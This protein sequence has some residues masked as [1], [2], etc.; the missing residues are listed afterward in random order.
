MRRKRRKNNQTKLIMIT[1]LSLLFILTVGYAAFSTN[2]N[3]TAKGNIKEKSRV[4]KSYTKTSKEDFH[5]DYYRPKIVTANFRKT[6]RVPNNAIE[7]W[8]VS[9]AKDGGVMA[10]LV[11]STKEG[12]YD[13]FIGANNGVIAN[14]NSD[15]L[16]FDFQSLWGIRFDSSFDT[17]NATSMRYMFN[18]GNNVE[19]IDLS[20]F[21]TTN[22]TSMYAMFSAWNDNLNGYGNRATTQIIFGENF[23]TSKVTDM[24]D[25]FSG[26]PLKSLNLSN[27]NTSNVTNMF[28]M[29]NKCTELTELNLCSFNTKNAT[30]MKEM[31]QYTEKIT[32]VKVGPNWV[33]PSSDVKNLFYGSNIS[34]VTTGQC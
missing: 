17:K 5:S 8:D 1:S 20:D 34:S 33:V 22:V 18:G 31:F 10:W 6:N 3:I 26:Q 28:H 24:G 32:K 14:Q 16:F 4:I 21:D 7:S 23:N 9:E 13:L 27:F 30:N 19:T 12:Y 29:F 25:M 15:F 11:S 2:I